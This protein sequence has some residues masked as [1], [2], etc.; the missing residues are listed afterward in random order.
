MDVR[1][2]IVAAGIVLVLGIGL[3]G[4]SWIA[5]TLDEG[6]KHRLLAPCKDL[7]SSDEQINCI[8]TY[9]DPA[10]EKGDL[11]GAFALFSTAY[12]DFVS[13]SGT[14]CHS[15][16]HRVGDTAYYRYY[17]LGE[18]NI[19]AMDFPQEATACG[20][21]FFHGF[22]E[23]LIQDHPDPE[24]AM[25]VCGMLTEKLQETMSNIRTIC[26]H[27]TGHG[28][29]LANAESIPKSEWGNLLRFT[30]D[31]VAECG[32]MDQATE[33]E[34]EDCRQG[35]FNV[36]VSWME[37]KNYGFVYNEQAPFKLCD[38]LPS[39]M[40][41]ACYYEMAQKLNKIAHN[42][43][44]ELEAIAVTTPTPEL[45]NLVFGIGV[46]GIIQNVIAPSG[47]GPTLERCELLSSAFFHLCVE[48][49]IWGLF[50]HGAPQQEYK[51]ALMVCSEPALRERGETA[52]CYENTALRLPRFYADHRITSIC[53][54]FPEEFTAVCTEKAT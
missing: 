42:D 44:V 9:I 15:H 17:I 12:E 46:A 37:V 10:I 47:Y 18:R 5:D 28:Y 40:Q 20:Y 24:F 31:P 1:Q 26:Y 7:V 39:S 29:T 38:S 50:E 52:F 14:G 4:G 2:S 3:V 49:I 19:D 21:G 16:A 54:E 53:Q 8:F 41:H 34:R 43:P 23:H 25:Q 11:E 30:E 45:A 51:Q 48:N 32:K 36:I 33:S 27:G 13:F 6:A 35:V 22:L